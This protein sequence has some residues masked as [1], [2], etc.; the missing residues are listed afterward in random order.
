MELEKKKKRGWDLPSEKESKGST[1][2]LILW[3]RKSMWRHC[4]QDESL[5]KHQLPAG[6]TNLLPSHWTDW[7]IDMPRD[8]PA[9]RTRQSG[10]PQLFLRCC[11]WYI[12]EH[13]ALQRITELSFHVSTQSLHSVTILNIK[14]LLT[15]LRL[16]K[17]AEASH[18]GCVYVQM[19][20]WV[21]DLFWKRASANF[22]KQK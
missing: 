1:K 19:I 3:D 7:G 12:I 21:S 18:R 14:H 8:G 22:K 5:T 6:V 20:E 10:D 4:R 17:D 15:P 16:L 13:A 9:D 11:L 2:R